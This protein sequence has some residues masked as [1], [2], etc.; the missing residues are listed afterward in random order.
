M[1]DIINN[2]WD[3]FSIFNITGQLAIMGKNN[4]FVLYTKRSTLVP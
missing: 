3:V 4:L 2:L 1:N